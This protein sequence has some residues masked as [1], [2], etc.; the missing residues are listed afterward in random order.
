M[1]VHVTCMFCSLEVGGEVS[2]DKHLQ[3][4]H[5][6]ARQRP[7]LLA[8]LLLTHQDI[9]E[10]VDRVQRRAEAESSSRDILAKN[11]QVSPPDPG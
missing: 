2:L 9:A 6:V 1:S 11:V 4:G 3:Y 5:G 8:L 7:L 10:L